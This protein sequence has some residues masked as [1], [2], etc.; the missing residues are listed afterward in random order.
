MTDTLAPI[1]TQNASDALTALTVRTTQ[2]DV[3]TAPHGLTWASPG[4]G[5]WVASRHDET[6]TTFLGFVEESL[7]EYL[8]VDGAGVSLGRFPDL[9]SAQAAFSG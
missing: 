8:A 1:R 6:G 2:H 7:E 5:L 3:V 9:R 4:N